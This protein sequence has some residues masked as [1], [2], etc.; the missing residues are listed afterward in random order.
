MQSSNVFL[1]RDR[2]R[3]V[4]AV[5]TLLV[6]GSAFLVKVGRV[7]VV[8]LLKAVL[9]ILLLARSR[10]ANHHTVIWSNNRTKMNYRIQEKVVDDNNRLTCFEV[11]VV[12]IDDRR[13][14]EGISRHMFFFDAVGIAKGVERVVG[15]RRTRRHG[16]DHHRPTG[17]VSLLFTA[18]ATSSK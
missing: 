11:D 18:P 14:I 4:L 2:V 6:V 10:R 1:T 15:G 12:R 16:S 9:D 5:H 7:V 17:H 3:S 8:I 13:T